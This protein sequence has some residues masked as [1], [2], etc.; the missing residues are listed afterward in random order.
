MN[1]E[2]FRSTLLKELYALD[3]TRNYKVIRTKKDGMYR[4]FLILPIQGQSSEPAIDL[5]GFYEAHKFP[6][7]DS[8]SKLAQIFYSHIRTNELLENLG[9]DFE[10]LKDKICCRLVNPKRYDMLQET[11]YIQYLDLAV[12]FYLDLDIRTTDLSTYC[13]LRKNCLLDWN[14]HA[15]DLFETARKNTI[16][17]HPFQLI[18]PADVLRE[19][20]PDNILEKQLLDTS[21]SENDK[22]YFLNCPNGGYS[23]TALLYPEFFEDLTEKMQCDLSLVILDNNHVAV[24]PL[25]H[26]P[27]KQSFIQ[28]QYHTYHDVLS[29][30]VYCYRKNT[31][32]I[33]MLLNFN[34]RFTE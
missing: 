24:E 4:E 8:I 6:E 7:K 25:Q 2:L 32:Q 12:I 14:I 13:I 15:E 28:D 18:S 22:L 17:R 31:K 21:L 23:S 16:R 9:N 30:K 5:S 20:F 27:E 10:S 33:S 1:Y 29:D 3:S 34:T 19:V 11:P 26:L